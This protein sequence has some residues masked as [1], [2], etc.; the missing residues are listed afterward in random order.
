MLP[1]S[2]CV[3]RH[4]QSC[5]VARWWRCLRLR[6]EGATASELGRSAERAAERYL[7]RRGLRLIARNYRTRLGEIDLVMS[8]ADELV[9]VEVRFRSSDSFGTGSDTVDAK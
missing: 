9:F 6:R 1:G 8:H 7:E 2:W 4:G 3:I 5:S